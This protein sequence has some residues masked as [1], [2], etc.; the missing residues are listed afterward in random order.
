MCL[1][2]NVSAH[3][4]IV[5]SKGAKSHG[6]MLAC[7]NKNICKAVRLKSRAKNAIA[8]KKSFLIVEAKKERVIVRIK[9]KSFAQSG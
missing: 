9:N 4:R 5:K 8:I 6:A 3:E 2:I 1:L 7:T